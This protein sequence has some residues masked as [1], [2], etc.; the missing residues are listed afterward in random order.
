MLSDT[1]HSIYIN[2]HSVIYK[3][4][5]TGK[6]LMVTQF[7][8]VCRDYEVDSIIV[9]MSVVKINVMVCVVIL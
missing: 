4:I 7:I 3:N 2:T 9:V 5:Y 1:V 8:H 6:C